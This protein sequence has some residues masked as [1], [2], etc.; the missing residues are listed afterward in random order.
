ML[1]AALAGLALLAPLQASAQAA[2]DR[3]T[4]SVMPYLWLPSLDAKLNY[5]PPPASGASANVDVNASTLLENLDFA[6]MI[7]GEARKGRWLLATDVIYLD[8]SSSDSKV[9]SV[10]FNPG[11]GRVNISTAA[12]DAGTNVKLTGWLWTA[13]G[14]YAAVQAPRA[15]LDVIGGLR[16]LGLTAKTDWQLTTTVT[17]PAGTTPFARTGSVEKSKDVWTAIVGAKGRAK[18]GEGDWFLNYYVDLGGGSSTFTWQGVAGVGYAFKWG[19]LVLDYRYLSYSQSGD[20]LFDDLSLGGVALG[21]S[22]RF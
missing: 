9:K 11:P 22:F 3:W 21:A 13:V 18:L 2:A 5:G 12:L 6:F 20:K 7:N 15:S 10:D 4:F 17:G 19:E 14:G 1:T 16:Y 8:L